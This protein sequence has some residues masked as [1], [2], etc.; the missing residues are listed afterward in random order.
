MNSFIVINIFTWITLFHLFTVSN[1]LNKNSW[2]AYQVKV[3]KDI[4]ANMITAGF[5]LCRSSQSDGQA[6]MEAP[7]K[8]KG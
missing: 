2:A 7:E 6:N 5:V 1:S 3:G 4:P 8:K